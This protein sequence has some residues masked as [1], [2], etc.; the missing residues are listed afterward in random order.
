MV[1]GRGAEQDLVALAPLHELADRRR[2]VLATIDQRDGTVVRRALDQV[3][4][5]VLAPVRG[6]G[7][8]LRRHDQREG[9]F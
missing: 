3:Q 8:A 5:F 1:L 4:R 2:G 9:T 7:V 6:V